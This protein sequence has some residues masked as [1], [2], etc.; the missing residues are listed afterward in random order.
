MLPV[1]INYLRINGQKLSRTNRDLICW[2]GDMELVPHLLE[3]SKQSSVEVE[4]VVGE[5]LD[6]QGHHDTK[7]IRD[8]SREVVARLFKPLNS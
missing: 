4:L 2:Y 3:L 1:A 6:A 5:P 8:Q 7:Q